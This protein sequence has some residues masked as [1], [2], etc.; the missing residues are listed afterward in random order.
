MRALVLVGLIGCSPTDDASMPDA[1]VPAP[2]PLTSVADGLIYTASV[3]VGGQSFALQ[4]DSGSTTVAVAG[5]SCAT[6]TGIAPTYAPVN[7]S[8]QH[9]TATTEYADMSMWSGEI[10]ADQVGL[11]GG[12]H[13]ISLDFVSITSQTSFFTSNDYQGILGLGPTDLEAPGTTSFV[14]QSMMAGIPPVLAFQFCSDHGQLWMGG[15][16]PAFMTS[17]PQYSP[18]LPMN[19]DDPFYTV[20][21]DDIG[22]G[23][24][25]LG[26]SAAQIGPAL[27]DTGTGQFVVPQAIGDALATAVQNSAG[28]QALFGTQKWADGMGCL[29]PTVVTTDAQIDAMLPPLTL[30]LPATD[31]T[32]F[33]LTLSPM[34]SYMFT[35]QG[36]Y[37]LAVES[38]SDFTDTILGDTIMR[39]FIT[40]IDLANGRIGF[41]PETGC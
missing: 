10:F 30:V 29:S 21:V 38:V 39:A 31:G 41:A 2:V 1:G 34:K 28:F 3:S 6:C 17:P 14:G 37:C 25:S 16:D 40:V 8:D 22:I 19:T 13:P 33:T 24:T 11:V 4:V 35:V 9:Q 5:A 18:M 7:A 12:P 32:K 26:F 27:A 15:F 23:G 20:T 36:G